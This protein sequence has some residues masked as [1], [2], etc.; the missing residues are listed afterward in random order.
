MRLSLRKVKMDLGHVGSAAEWT[1]KVYTI[2]RVV[3]SRGAPRYKLG[4]HDKLVFSD[5]L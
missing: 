2:D 5:R 1:K 4:G 3:K